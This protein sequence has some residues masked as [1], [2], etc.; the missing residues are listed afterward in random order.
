[1]DPI[2]RLA[3]AELVLHALL[4]RPPLT[5]SRA[6]A[7]ADAVGDAMTE[8]AAALRDAAAGPC[9]PRRCACC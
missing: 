3:H 5:D 8:L 9:E 6:G 7:L 1:M 4:S 2:S